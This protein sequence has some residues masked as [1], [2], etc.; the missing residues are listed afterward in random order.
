MTDRNAKKNANGGVNHRRQ[1][2]QPV[3]WSRERG[4]LDLTAKVF[5]SCLQ[6]HGVN[7]RGLYTV[8]KVCP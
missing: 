1:R 3:P 6:F 4:T 8:Q 5:W 2:V 7:F